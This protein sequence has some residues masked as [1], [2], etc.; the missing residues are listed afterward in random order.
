MVAI[1]ENNMCIQK[2]FDDDVAYKTDI[3]DIDE[4]LDGLVALTY[5][6]DGLLA[7]FN[8]D[9]EIVG[10]TLTDLS[11]KGNHGTMRFFNM[12]DLYGDESSIMFDGVDDVIDI[13]SLINYSFTNG[14][15]L[16]VR[17]R[18][19]RTNDAYILGN[20]ESSGASL[21]VNATGIRNV[22]WIRPSDGSTAGYKQFTIPHSEF[23][24]T[25]FNTYVLTYDNNSINMYINGNF[26]DS[27]DIAGK[28]G[29]SYEP[30]TI[31][32]N[33]NDTPPNHTYNKIAKMDLQS[34]MIYDR[35]LTDAEVFQNYHKD[36][37]IFS[38]PG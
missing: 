10:E 3:E 15:T 18:M 25:Q 13:N 11:G 22:V 7:H 27:L 38:V 6:K 23:D 35:A 30:Y 5:V 8:I 31:G 2:G 16:V 12:D 14:I 36:Q 37:E 34:V 19:L 17:T 28:I 32:G 24:Y 9:S 4:C 1:F 33:P 21:E 29:P 20:A 26:K